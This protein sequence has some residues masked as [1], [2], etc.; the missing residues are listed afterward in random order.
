MVKYKLATPVEFD[1]ETVTEIELPR[2]KGRH[3]KE[4]GED[5][6]IGAIILVAR[7]VTGRPLK[8]FDELDGYDYFKIGEIYNN[9]LEIGPRTGK[10]DS[11]S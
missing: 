11:E 1:G 5:Q 8:F 7:K 9:F 10:Q 4:L 2:P 3:L 6:S